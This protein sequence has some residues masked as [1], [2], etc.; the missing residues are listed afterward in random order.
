VLRKWLGSKVISGAA[1]TFAFSQ[2]KDCG[3]VAL[4]S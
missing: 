4:H 1:R 3:S 2:K